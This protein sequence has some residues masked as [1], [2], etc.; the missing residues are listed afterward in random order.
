MQANETYNNTVKLACAK[1]AHAWTPL[2]LR[3]LPQR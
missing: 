1:A 2:T 3:H